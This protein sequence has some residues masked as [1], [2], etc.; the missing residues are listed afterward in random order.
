MKDASGNLS[1]LLRRVVV[2]ALA[3][4]FAMAYSATGHV[5]LS[6]VASTTLLWLPVIGVQVAIALLFIAGPGAGPA[7]ST[8][9]VVPALAG[10][11][12]AHVPWTLYFLLAWTW[13]PTLTY[14]PIMPMLVCG[15]VPLALTGWMIATFF[16][17]VLKL[18]WRQAWRRTLM[19]QAVT[20]GTLIGL[21]SAAVAMWPRILE[22]LS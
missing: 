18:S 4:G 10:F 5:T 21:Y 9:G 1:V 15:L 3:L 22:Q 11:F 6:L 19:H 13:A 12:K 2:A 20:W 14:H 16:R 17:D 8:V 7:R